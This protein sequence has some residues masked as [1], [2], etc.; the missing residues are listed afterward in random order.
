MNDLLPLQTFQH[1]VRFNYNT[2][3]LAL[4][5]LLQSTK[6]DRFS[7]TWVSLVNIERLWELDELCQT[8]RMKRMKETLF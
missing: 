3:L 2:K 6:L 8:A 7:S 1:N 4:S 5:Y